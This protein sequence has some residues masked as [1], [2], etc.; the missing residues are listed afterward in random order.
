MK[1]GLIGCGHLGLTIGY[2][3]KK[4]SRLYGVYDIDKK[5][6]TR[7]IRILKIKHNP[8]YKR[9]IKECNILLFAT[10]DD[11]ILDAF[12]KAKKYFTDKKY[13]FHFS[14]LLPAEIFPK[15][16][17]IYRATLHPFATFPRIII[18]PHRKKY[19]LFFQGDKQSYRVTCAIFL[20][21]NFLIRSISKKQKPIYHLLGVFSSNLLVALNEAIW[22]LAK[23]LKWTE[24]EFKE[25]IFPM[26]VETISNVKEYG[27]KN[28]LS[29]PMVRGDI[30]SIKKHMIIL[31][32][33]P[34]FCD[35]YCA[36]SRIIVKY[37]PAKKQKLL[38]RILHF[39]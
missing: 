4:S 31:K 6:L 33:D 10:P 36:L 17:N 34:K 19:I 12:K 30:K 11:K 16:K 8:D 2:F 39:N 3:L 13:L 32:K 27:V 28:G 21:K 24:K 37:A 25:V 26:I 35:I 22:C 1:I 38:K 18:P 20:R 9:L 7:A 5:A 14:G 23:R 15:N 29:G